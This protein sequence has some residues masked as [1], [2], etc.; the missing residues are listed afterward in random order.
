MS[1]PV[2]EIIFSF[3]D[4]TEALVRL[5]VMSPIAGYLLLN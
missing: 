4:P 3:I 5:L 1:N 2:D